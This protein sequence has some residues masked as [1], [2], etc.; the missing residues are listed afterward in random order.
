M[1]QKIRHIGIVKSVQIQP[2]GMKVKTPTGEVYD[3]TRR[4]VVAQLGI[5]PDGVV[6]KGKD[7]KPILDIHHKV[8]P[9]SH[10]RPGNQIS[11]GF[12]AH[13]KAMRYRFGDHM[14]VGSAGENVIIKFSDE[15][16]LDSLGKH[17][18]FEN[19]VSGGT[20]LLDVNGVAT[21][22]VPFSHFA[23]ASPYTQLPSAKLKEVIRFLDHGRRGFLLSLNA[24]QEKALIHPGDQ[25]FVVSL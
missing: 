16:W 17:L 21:P 15:V 9:N 3:A 8:H 11:I 20:T 12:T 7:G 13:Y 22:C 5:T 6:A 10:H 14:V 18:L 24:S 19:P 25:V 23:A 1:T 4:K 2:H